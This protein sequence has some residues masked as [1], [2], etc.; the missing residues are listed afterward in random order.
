MWAYVYTTLS[1]AQLTLAYANQEE[2]RREKQKCTFV[3][4][5]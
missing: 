4:L 1:T 5:W 3:E 2:H